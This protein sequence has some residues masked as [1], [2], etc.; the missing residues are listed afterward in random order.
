[1]CIAQAQAQPIAPPPAPP[2][3]VRP[4]QFYH[5]GAVREV[6]KRE[7]NLDAVQ[8][9]IVQHEGFVAGDYTD[10]KGISTSGVGQT[11]IY[12]GKTF[13]ETYDIHKQKAKKLVPAFDNLPE[14]G[15]KGHYVFNVS[16]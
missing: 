6:I 16:R 12:K 13:K 3:I 5:D 4:Q 1:M 2:P 9:Y 11:G 7:G 14:Q 10:T 8:K 15:Q